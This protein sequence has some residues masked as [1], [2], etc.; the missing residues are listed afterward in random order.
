[1]NTTGICYIV[2]G[3]ISL[4]VYGVVLF[5][6]L[7]GDCLDGG[8]IISA[9]IFSIAQFIIS[10]MSILAYKK[11]LFATEALST[12]NEQMSILNGCGD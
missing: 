3:S 6:G 10:I 8:S 7:K 12:M 5:V 1:M 4:A 2:F 9:Q 11:T